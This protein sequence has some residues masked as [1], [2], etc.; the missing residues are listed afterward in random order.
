MLSNPNLYY[1]NNTYKAFGTNNNPSCYNQEINSSNCSGVD[2]SVAIRNALYN[3]SDHLPVTLEIETDQMLLS[4]SDN[5]ISQITFKIIGT[6]M[7]QDIIK[8]K[9]DDQ[10]SRLNSLRVYNV[11]GQLVKIV[12]IEQ[13]EYLTIDTSTLTT[14]IYYIVAPIVNVEPLKF[15]KVN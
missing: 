11:L 6:N 15:V 2:Y 7:V 8:L 14:G 13:S 5:L 4:L 10:V 1:V 12:P 3:F 9:V